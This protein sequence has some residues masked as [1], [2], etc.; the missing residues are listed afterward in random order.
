M[1]TTAVIASSSNQE[2]KVMHN[3][4][5]DH[6]DLPTFDPSAMT[7]FDDSGKKSFSDITSNY[8]LQTETNPVN[9]SFIL[10]NVDKAQYSI[11]IEK[12]GLSNL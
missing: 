6:T 1:D 12:K 11:A 9:L 3:G 4:D 5:A 2:E 7:V 8:V 10:Q